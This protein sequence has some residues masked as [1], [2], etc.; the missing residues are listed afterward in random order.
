MKLLIIEDD[1]TQVAALA[2]LISAK[3]NGDLTIAKAGSLA[4]GH[5]QI[6]REYPDAVLLDLDLPDSP[7]WRL[8]VLHI[9]ELPKPLIVTTGVGSQGDGGEGDQVALACLIAGAE[10]VY[11]KPFCTKATESLIGTIAAAVLRHKARRAVEEKGLEAALREAVR[12][13]QFNG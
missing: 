12:E 3:T 6:Q 13:L 2:K 1:E 7:N 9:P 5:R 11:F 8:T 4:E 10:N